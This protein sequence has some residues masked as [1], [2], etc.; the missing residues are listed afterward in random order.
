MDSA[1]K[2]G[3]IDKKGSWYTRGEEKIGQGKENAVN[4]IENNPDYRI[5]L[6]HTLREKVFP[7]QVLRTKEGDV[8]TEDQIR[9][10]EKEMRSRGVGVGSIIAEPE[11]E[12]MAPVSVVEAPKTAKSKAAAASASTASSTA[13]SFAKAAASDKPLPEDLF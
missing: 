6:E 5:E 1:V 12:S 8:V 11:K 2:H 7:G 10:Y 9:A 13:T 4:F 3:L